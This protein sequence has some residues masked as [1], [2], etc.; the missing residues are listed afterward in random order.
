[1][2]GGFYHQLYLGNDANPSLPWK[3]TNHIH[4][5]KAMRNPSN[6][7]LNLAFPILLWTKNF[8]LPTPSEH[9]LIPYKTTLRMAALIIIQILLPV[10]AQH[11]ESSQCDPTNT[12]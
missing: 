5:L 4:L 3:F 1:M 12:D 2:G 8:L 6:G 11:G 9:L 7:K 10:T